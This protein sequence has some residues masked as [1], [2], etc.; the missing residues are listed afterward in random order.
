MRR[1]HR[2][3]RVSEELLKEISAIIRNDIKDPRVGNFVS[4]VRVALT[5]DIRRAKVYV[6]VYGP[7]SEKNSTIEALRHGAGFVRSLIGKRLR[8]RVAPEINFVLD[9]SIE[10]SA[11]INAKLKEIM[12]GPE[13]GS[14]QDTE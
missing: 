3:E 12:S 13:T 1:F 9:D 14:N 11:K 8:I 10:Y 2:S 7:D 4:I 6:S 5:K